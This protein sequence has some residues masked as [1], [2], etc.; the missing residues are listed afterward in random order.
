MKGRGGVPLGPLEVANSVRPARWDP[1]RGGPFFA[2]GP[3]SS[4]DLFIAKAGQIT[5]L[6]LVN[7]R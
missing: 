6:S 5:V 1:F 7:E 3:R 2:R 4:A